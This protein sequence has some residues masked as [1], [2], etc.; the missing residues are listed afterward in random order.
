MVGPD[1]DKI[2]DVLGST[3][4]GSRGGS[5]IPLIRFDCPD[6]GEIKFA[7]ESL[8]RQNPQPFATIS[9]VWSDGWGNEKINKLR[10]CQLRFI[11]RQLRRANGGKDIPFWMDT[12][13]VPVR[14]FQ[15]GEEMDWDWREKKTKAIA[16]IFELFAKSSFTVILDNGL[17]SMSPGEQEKPADAAMKILASGWMRRLWT[18][19]EAFLSKKRYVTFLESA[20]EHDNLTNLEALLEQLNT[21]AAQKSPLVSWVREL[22]LQ[23]IMDQ[24]AKILADPEKRFAQRQAAM[25]VAGTW[26]AATWRVSAASV[27]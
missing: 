1:M 4:H 9:H 25:L 16:Q 15:D 12:L 8:R 6:D 22:L 3:D 14:E 27:T 5:D 7:V 26:R 24:E 2:L 18:L 10:T 21:P 23:N 13:I 11:R 17:C 19:H 20:D